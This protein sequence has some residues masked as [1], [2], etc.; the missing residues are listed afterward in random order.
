MYIFKNQCFISMDFLFDTSHSFKAYT[1]LH[2]WP[3]G[4]FAFFMCASV[5]Y[6]H[7]ILDVKQRI[8]FGFLLSIIPA[9]CVLFRIVMTMIDGTF[10]LEEELPFHLCRS[11]ALVF[12]F[13]IY[14]QSRRW[15]GILY[16]FTVVGALQA[17][18]TP[19]LPLSAPHHSYWSYWALHCVLIGLPIYCIVNFRWKVTIRDFWNA[20]IVGNIYLVFT[21]I[22]NFVLGSNYFF[23]SHKPPSPTLLD[24]LGPWPWYILAVEGVAFVL[25]LLA[26]LPFW[27]GRKTS[28]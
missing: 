23:T 11:L 26:G 28:T 8:A 6:A 4:V 22:I 3:L 12:P 16:F 17:L 25:F 24:V 14:Y 19:D 20:V 5:I 7:R 13:V 10:S 2:W 1:Y 15:F 21:G 18:L 9:I 27:I